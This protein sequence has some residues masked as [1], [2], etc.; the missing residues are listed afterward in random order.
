VQRRKISLATEPGQLPFGIA[1]GGLLDRRDAFGPRNFPADQRAKFAKAESLFHSRTDV[2]RGAHFFHNSGREHFFD[3]TIDPVV[4][5]DAIAVD[6]DSS[7]RSTG[8]LPVG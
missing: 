3:A 6:E 8:I 5:L 4:E 7:R 1:P 2:F